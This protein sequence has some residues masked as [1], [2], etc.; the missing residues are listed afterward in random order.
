MQLNREEIQQIIPHRAPF[1]LV[2]RVL[3]LRPGKSAT[4]EKDVSENEFFF[5]GHFPDEFVMPGVLIV[6]ALAQTGAIIVLSQSENA[7]KRIYFAGLK[8][9]KFRRKVI[10]GDTLRLE[11]VLNRIKGKFGTGLGKAYVGEELAC[12]AEFVFSFS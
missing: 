8:R 1:L 4:A 10:P 9:V 5:P 3:E 11:A 6:E 12:E 2:D 7:N